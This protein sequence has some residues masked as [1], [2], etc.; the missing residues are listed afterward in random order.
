MPSYRRARVSG[1]TFFPTVTLRERGSDLLL[2]EVGALRAAFRAARR[3]RPF[4]IEAA[5]VL[6]DHLHPVMRLPGGDGDFSTRIGHVK[7]AFARAVPEAAPGFAGRPGK[8]E[9]GVWQ[10][11]F[12]EHAIRDDADF[13]AHVRYCWIKPVKHGLVARATDWPWSS[14]HRDAPGWDGGVH[15]AV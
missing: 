8:G 9:R 10:R 12:W 2:R 5:V 15:P 1:G 14:V 3:A 11:R 7:A 13:A 6:P 4:A